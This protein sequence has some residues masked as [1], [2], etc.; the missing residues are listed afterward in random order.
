MSNAQVPVVPVYL[1]QKFVFDLIAML[2]GGMATVTKVTETDKDASKKANEIGGGFGLSEALSWLMKVNLSGK[3]NS[4]AEVSKDRTIAEERVHTPSSLF[5]TLRQL[6]LEREYLNQDKSGYVPAPGQF[7]EF[8]AQLKK[9]PLI[10][11]IESM[12]ELMKMGSVFA[13]PEAKK[14]PK[15]QPGGKAQPDAKTVEKQMDSFIKLIK[16]GKMIDLV[17]TDL[18]CSYR[19]VITLE[20]QFLNDPG[21]FDLVDGT[22]TVVGKVT[23]S[24]QSDGSVNL[25]RNSPLAMLPKGIFQQMIG[26]LQ[27]L[28]EN[29]QFELPEMSM[30]VPAPVLQVL[31]VCIFA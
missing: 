5:F 28:T 27:A 22:F 18:A 20:N 3:R 10:E 9:N 26:A 13:E 17:T 19:C 15:N 12:R 4:S 7:M 1:N 30:E 29:H 14:G 31:P 23:R 16:T 8:S 21:M 6:M 2:E 24:V 25:F 11:V